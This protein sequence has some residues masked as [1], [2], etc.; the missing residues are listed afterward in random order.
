MARHPGTAAL[1]SLLGL[2]QLGGAL[3]VILVTVIHLYDSNGTNANGTLNQTCLLGTDTNGSPLCILAYCAGGASA[4]VTAIAGL[5]L[6]I[7]CRCCGFG[8][9][10]DFIVG[11]L[12]TALWAVV[13]AIF[14]VNTRRANDAGLPG[15][16]W[17]FA[18]WLTSFITAGLFLATAILSMFLACSACFGRHKERRHHD[19][20]GKVIVA[21]N[22]SYGDDVAHGGKRKRGCCGCGG[23]K[24]KN[25]P[26]STGPVAA[27][28]VEHGHG[29][30]VHQ[31][32]R[33]P[34]AA[35]A[36]REQPLTVIPGG[37]AG[38]PQPQFIVDNNRRVM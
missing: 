14:L 31:P 22:N 26:Y 38:R 2:L 27:R 25:G 29:L 24:A 9:I 6:C 37:M 13:G 15:G 12:G 7:T 34:G 23:R 20:D 8:H 10:I 16:N 28:D 30:D 35:E 18:V 19:A 17:R 3:T 5:L 32:H 4:I 33:H 36:Y 1:V 21:G 11:I